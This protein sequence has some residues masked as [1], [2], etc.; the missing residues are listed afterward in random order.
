M[1]SSTP[2]TNFAIGNF[3][4]STGRRSALCAGLLAIFLVPSFAFSA[5]AKGT[6]KNGILT[7][8][9]DETYSIDLSRKVTTQ[10]TGHSAKSSKILI[11]QAKT[12]RNR[13]N[14]VILKITAGKNEQKKNLIADIDVA[15]QT[16]FIPTGIQRR[17]PQNKR[18]VVNRRIK[19]QK[20]SAGKIKVVVLPQSHPK[21]KKR[22]KQTP[23]PKLRLF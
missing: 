2:N 21:C 23:K 14:H 13:Q 1:L 3:R 12:V 8:C 17:N 6:L 20:G 7:I 9:P 5:S 10:I 22:V 11:A 18:R 15:V 16:G 19:T 4:C